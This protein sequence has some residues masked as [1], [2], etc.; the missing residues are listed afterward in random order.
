MDIYNFIY[1]GYVYGLIEYCVNFLIKSM[2]YPIGAFEKCM[3][4]FISTIPFTS[5]Y[6]F[7]LWVQ[8]V[9]FEFYLTFPLKM[10]LYHQFNNGIMTPFWDYMFDTM[11]EDYRNLTDWK[12]YFTGLPYFSFLNFMIF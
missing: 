3:L 6:T 4:M 1:Y 9:L 10:A 12:I 5:E 7:F 2:N 11:N 8:Y